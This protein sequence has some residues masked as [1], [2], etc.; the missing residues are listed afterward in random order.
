MNI[1][2]RLRLKL[3]AGAAFFALVGCGRGKE[4]PLSSAAVVPLLPPSPPTAADG[5]L[6]GQYES[7][8]LVGAAIGLA[9]IQSETEDADILVK[10]FSS[11][12]AENIM[13]PQSLS[14]AEGVYNFADADALVNFSEANGIA[15]RG[16]TLLW[17]RQTPDYFFQG[18][19]IEVKDRLQKYITDVVTHF[20]GKVYAWDVVNEVVTDNGSD[21]T[22]LTETVDGIKPQETAKITLIGHLKPPVPLTL[23]QSFF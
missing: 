10:Q 6:K 21:I 1:N 19:P 23:T 7:N 2:A 9:Q 17:H 20:K 13:K 16:H 22:A 14:P 12:T 8:F 18:T 3:L 4:L 5:A 11:I 15:I